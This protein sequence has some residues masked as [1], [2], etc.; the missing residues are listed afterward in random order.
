MQNICTDGAFTLGPWPLII[1]LRSDCFE[2]SSLGLYALHS[3]HCQSPA[4]S[5]VDTNDTT[6][7]LLASVTESVI[8][9]PSLRDKKIPLL[10][11]Y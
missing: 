4:W 6:T 11:L 1:V 10:L 9:A 5:K 3:L 2:L 8:P 7:S